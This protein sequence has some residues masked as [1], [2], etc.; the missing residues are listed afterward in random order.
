[1]STPHWPAELPA[2]LL[3]GSG[4]ADRD[5][6][7]RTEV[8]KGPDKVRRRSTVDLTDFT[9]PY[10]LEPEDFKILRAFHRND[11]NSGATSFWWT[12]PVTQEP[13]ECRFKGPIAWIRIERF[14]AVTLTIEE[15]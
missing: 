6:T 15:V 3:E 10:S 5:N 1:M 8:S 11:C 13:I 9:A 7:I 14:Y 2:P 12:D 4:G